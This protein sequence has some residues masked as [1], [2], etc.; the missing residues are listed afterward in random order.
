MA[1]RKPP[2]W[3]TALRRPSPESYPQE[4]K[5]YTSRR[6][7]EII[8]HIR[9]VN[10]KW[11]FGK[12]QTL[13]KLNKMV[14]FNVYFLIKSSDMDGL[15][16]P[17]KRY[18]L[19]HWMEKTRPICLLPG[20]RP[21][22]FA[23]GMIPYQR[24]WGLRCKSRA[25]EHVRQNDRAQSYISSHWEHLLPCWVSV[26]S[27][28]C[29]PFSSHWEGCFNSRR[30][31]GWLLLSLTVWCYWLKVPIEKVVVTLTASLFYVRLGPSGF[32]TLASIK[33]A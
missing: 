29:F 7:Q 4:R 33:T 3:V 14:G 17:I 23:D 25:E 2:G 8:S 19:E 16:S 18:E 26:C 12:H 28:G 5:T 27:G 10:K 13:Q 1:P 30:N 32:M 9:T 11:E 24:L 15:S 20:R 31:L 21:A 22:V 6:L